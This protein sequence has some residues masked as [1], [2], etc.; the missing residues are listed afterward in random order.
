MQLSAIPF[1][2]LFHSNTK[3]QRAQR[4]KQAVQDEQHEQRD[5]D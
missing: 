4:T 5:D 1:Q 3:H 2:R